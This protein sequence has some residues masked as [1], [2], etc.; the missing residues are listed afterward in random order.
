MPLSDD[1]KAMLRLLAQREQGYEDLAALMGLS[2]DEVRAK[3]KDAL[4]Q[5]EEEGAEV[6]VVPEAATVAPPAAP[7]EPASV[8]EPPGP[9]I[10][11]EPAAA[12]PPQPEAPA[13]PVA[14]EPPA[15]APEPPAA[16]KPAPE[17]G[18]ASA[19]PALG[20]A[21]PRPKP[22]RP[23]PSLPKSGGARAA[24]AAAVAVLV[25]LVIVLVVS[26][27]GDSGDTTTAG[28]GESTSA[29]EETASNA[30]PNPNLTQAVLS[31]V[32]GGDGSGLAVFGRIKKNVVLQVE[33]KGLDPSPKGS[34][35]TVWLYKSPK[36]ALRLGSV[37]VSKSGG[38]AVQLPVPT[39]L[40]AYVASGAFNQ[41]DL[42]L[43]PTAAY[44]AEIAKAKKEKRLP[45][46]MGEDVLRGPITGPAIEAA[47]KKQ[48]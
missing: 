26:G 22:S 41:I 1:Q 13:E 36:L 33:A 45:V 28:S 17:P 11:A 8:P 43:T 24:L 15:P 32:N 48:G 35:Y 12:E 14:V 19:P 30:S 29:S 23:R 44:E 34:A 18:K 5:L 6:P 21:A 46:Y 10:P 38:I 2:V 31:P 27:G 9:E 37:N 7:A 39:E 4:A 40:L 25:A 20:Q 3:V 42:S 47:Q 16:E